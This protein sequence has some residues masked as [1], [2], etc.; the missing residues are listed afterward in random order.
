MFSGKI[1]NEWGTEKHR[2]F[3][4]ESFCFVSAKFFCDVIIIASLIHNSNSLVS[5]FGNIAWS[6]FFFVLQKFCSETTS[7]V[8]IICSSHLFSRDS[9]CWLIWKKEILMTYCSYIAKV[10]NKVA[11]IIVEIIDLNICR[12]S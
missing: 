7:S 4:T 9:I 10:V 11:M 5:V 12:C 8:V 2:S 6:F 1:L 3:K